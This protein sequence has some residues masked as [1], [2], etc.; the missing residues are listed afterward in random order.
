[1]SFG[2]APAH[3]KEVLL[4]LIGT[5]ESRHDVGK[6]FGHRVGAERGVIAHRQH[7]EV[8]DLCCKAPDLLV[9]TADQVPD[10][11]GRRRYRECRRQVH[12]HV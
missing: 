11:N 4:H 12:G 1:M 9:G 10:R 6:A 5:F 2:F 3:G 7:E 8:A